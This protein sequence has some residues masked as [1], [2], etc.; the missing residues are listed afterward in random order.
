MA[1]APRSDVVD[2]AVA[3]PFTMPAHSYLAVDGAALTMRMRAGEPVE[4]S[5][6]FVNGTRASLDDFIADRSE[7]PLGERKAVLAYG[8]NAAVETLTRKFE[9]V[10]GVV[11]VAQARLFNFDVVYSAHFGPY[12]PIPATLQRS[13]GTTVGL[14]VTYLTEYQVAEMHATE[15]NYFFCRLFNIQLVFEN[16]N[17]QTD[18]LSYVTR[19]GILRFRGTEIALAAISATNRAFPGL[20]EEEILEQARQALAPD[21]DFETFVY[22]N[23]TMPDVARVRT[24]ALKRTAKAFDWTSWERLSG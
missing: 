3:Y 13:P 19:H 21:V 15:L 12:G 4:K 23:A 24:E 8:S 20:N 7:P 6:V 14:F 9:G 22:E 10:G 2:R 5:T 11:P 18:I 1:A 16:G 17:V